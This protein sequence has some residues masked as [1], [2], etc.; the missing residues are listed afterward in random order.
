M[1]NIRI[2]ASGA[3]IRIGAINASPPVPG[4]AMSSTTISGRWPSSSSASASSPDIA[5]RTR[6]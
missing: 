5:R 4:S 1:E 6:A 2:A 3:R